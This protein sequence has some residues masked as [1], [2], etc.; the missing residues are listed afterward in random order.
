MNKFITTSLFIAVALLSGAG[1]QRGITVDYIQ[2]KLVHSDDYYVSAEGAVFRGTGATD[3]VDAVRVFCTLYEK[4]CVQ[5]GFGIT[6]EGM[7]I[8][9]NSK[10]YTIIEST[11]TRLVAEYEAFAQVQYVEIDLL[12]KDVTFTEKDRDSSTVRSFILEDGVSALEKM[13]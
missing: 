9:Y 10:T 11:Q 6:K 1:C 8:L 12:S 7:A 3:G 13:K 4:S 5:N 2:Q